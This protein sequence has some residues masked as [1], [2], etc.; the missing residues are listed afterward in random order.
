M[1]DAFA[2]N[3]GFGEVDT[4]KG[5]AFYASEMSGIIGM[6]YASKSIDKLAPFIDVCSLNDK[7]FAFTFKNNPEKSYLTI[8]GYDPTSMVGDFIY[9][10]VVE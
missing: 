1:G 9:H 3:F 10:N 8:P 2:S 4:V 6:S 5:V 7:S